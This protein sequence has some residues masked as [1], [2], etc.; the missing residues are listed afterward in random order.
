MPKIKGIKS[1]FYYKI[2]QVWNLLP[3]LI[4]SITDLQMSEKEAMYHQGMGKKYFIQ[5][6]IILNE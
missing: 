6:I 5:L 2:I 3:D 4:I 1:K